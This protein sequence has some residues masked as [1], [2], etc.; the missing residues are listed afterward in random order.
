MT[1]FQRIIKYFALAL[2]FVI[3]VSIIGGIYALTTVFD[4]DRDYKYDESKF[5]S[6][7]NILVVDLK[8]TNLTIKKGDEL[9]VETSNKRIDVKKSNNRLIITE[10]GSFLSQTESVIVYVPEELIFDI[11]DIDTGAGKLSIYDLKSRNLDLDMGAGKVEIDNITIS[12]DAS[13]DGG[14]GEVII[15]NSNLTNLDLDVGVGKFTIEGRLNGRSDIDA[16]VGELNI[17]LDNLNDYSIHVTKGIGNISIVG[18]NIK[19][20]TIYGNGT[21][22]LEIDGGIGSINIDLLLRNEW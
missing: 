4:Y 11:V 2:A 19:N 15:T 16:G 20:D 3:I 14:A 17:R 1:T 10:R 13:I 6:S 21:N 9:K 5:D 22:K 18:E 7:A 8:K 12:D